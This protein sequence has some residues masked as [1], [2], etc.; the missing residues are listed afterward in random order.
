MS[1]PIVLTASLLALAVFCVTPLFAANPSP[2]EGNWRLIEQT[3]GEGQHNFVHVDD[4]PVTLTLMR[5]GEAWTGTLDWTSSRATWPAYPTPDGPATIER[6][7]FEQNPEEAQLT[8]SYRVLPAPGDDTYLVVVEKYSIDES[9][10]LLSHVRI[11]FE[12][13][14]KRVGGFDWH[15]KF[16]REDAR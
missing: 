15:R 5:Q 1:R 12:R 13:G 9:G 10:S 3:Y 2:L 11:E 4:D 16:E 7:E 14:G 6:V 8:V